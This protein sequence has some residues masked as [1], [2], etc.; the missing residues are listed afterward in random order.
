MVKEFF[1]ELY[2]VGPIRLIRGYLWRRKAQQIIN[3]F[4]VGD[5]VERCDYHIGPIVEMPEG[6]DWILV[7]S[8]F[9]GKERG[10]SILNCGVRHV[11]PD[12]VELLKSIYNEKGIDGILNHH[13]YTDKWIE[14][15]DKNWRTEK[16]E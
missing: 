3:S 15:F 10:C 5:I 1:Q 13:G 12:E 11:P 9:D 7:K 6:G 16:S 2:L 4:K 8:L 14:E